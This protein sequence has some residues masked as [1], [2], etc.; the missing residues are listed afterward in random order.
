MQISNERYFLERRRHDLALRMLRHE[1]RTRTINDC[2]GLSESQ[3]RRL[4][5]SYAL[6]HTSAP[7]RRHRGKSPRQVAYFTRNVR[8]QLAASVL[9]NLFNT[10]GL[11]ERRPRPGAA[12]M[13]FAW[14]FCDAFETHR[15]LLAATHPQLLDSQDLSI[16][17]AWFLLQHLHGGGELRISQCHVCTGQYLYSLARPHGHPCPACKLKKKPARPRPRQATLRMTGIRG[18]PAC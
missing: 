4:Y 5:Q 7:L 18:K 3:I 16:E 11:L 17:H 14:R 10:F 9:V 15:Q 6:R 2:T 8:I 1:A 12:G 13:E